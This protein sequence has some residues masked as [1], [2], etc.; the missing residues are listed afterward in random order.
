MYGDKL[1]ILLILLISGTIYAE[2]QIAKR[3]SE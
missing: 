3:Q 2:K 1:N